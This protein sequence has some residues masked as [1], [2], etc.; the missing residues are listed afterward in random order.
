M[1]ERGRPGNARGAEE[2]AAPRGAASDPSGDM[3]PGGSP[4]S[5]PIPAP[6]ADVAP[7][8][9]LRLRI[10]GE[11][12]R[13]LADRGGDSTRAGFRA[14]R[15]VG[16]GWVPPWHIPDPGEIRRETERELVKGSDAEARRLGGDRFDA[17]ADL[18][19][20]LGT[21]KRNPVKYPEGDAL[22]HSLQV[23][24]R[25][26]EECPW[27]EELLT[28]ALV[29]DVGLAIDRADPTAAALLALGDLVTDRTRWLV[30]M[31]PAATALHAGTLG[32]R[33]RHRLEAHPDHD[34]LLLLESADRR[35]HVRAGEAPTLEEAVATLR[36]L[37]GDAA[38]E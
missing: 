19:R 11:A 24:A 8:D 37:E 13:M 21:V 14:A 29:H 20:V 16:R 2:G 22:E 31:L 34:A 9:K 35:G 23:F 17:L 32:A 27:D 33:A 30:E 6:A 18:V 36:A 5:P 10:A 28:A 15:R 38:E 1:S 3:A 7:P 26:A 25:V 12:G 4:P